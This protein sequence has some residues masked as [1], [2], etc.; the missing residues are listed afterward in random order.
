M[1]VNLSI[2]YTTG[3]WYCRV[4][5]N[6]DWLFTPTIAFVTLGFTNT[7]SNLKKILLIALVSV[8]DVTT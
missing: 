7:L 8:I 1:S 3:A 4:T 2:K 6:Y 5:L